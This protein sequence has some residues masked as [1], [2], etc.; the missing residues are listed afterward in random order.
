MKRNNE[1]NV[2]KKILDISFAKKKLLTRIFNIKFLRKVKKILVLYSSRK[3]LKYHKEK[4]ILNY[5]IE[6]INLLGSIKHDIGLGESSR[7]VA[8]A[9]SLT[10]IPFVIFDYRSLNS[11]SN[12]DKQW[13]SK[14]SKDCPYPINIIHINP[15]ELTIAYMRLKK[16]MWKNKYN[17]AFW[18]WELEDFPDEWCPCINLLDEI[19]TPSEFISQSIRKK[20]TIP[21][22]TIPYGINI[23]TS[24]KYGRKHF[25]LPENQFLFLTMF[26]SNSTI[27]RK[28]PISPIK[29]FQLAFRKNDQKVGLVIKINNEKQE[30]IE[31]LKE[32]IGS[33]SNIYLIAK[34]ITKTE[35]NSLINEVDV[36]VS[37]HRAEG[38]GLPLAE[39][40]VLGTPTI[41]TNWSGNTQYMTNNNSCL[42][43]Y[44]FTEIKEDIGPYKKGSN[45]AEA[46]IIQ[47]ADYMKVLY[48]DSKLYNKIAKQAKEDMNSNFQPQHMANR[49]Y[50]RVE[51]IYMMNMKE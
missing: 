35:V 44:N 45:W 8:N 11:V 51:K 41:A 46:N 20:T 21:V 32:S 33:Y 43:N 12:N 39:A 24:N 9:L 6:G 5:P 50:K 14:I 18:L 40:M 15:F 30:D 34:T 22:I 48:S 19:W 37:L 16:D 23:V 4:I 3:I 29:A 2:I 10:K 17:I 26:D 13:E 38:F 27:E 7:I 47:A 31:I 28:N 42:V 36:L 1:E 25:S 49:I